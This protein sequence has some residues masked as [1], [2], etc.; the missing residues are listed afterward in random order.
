M[1]AMAALLLCAIPHANAAG[2]GT[3]I[4]TVT[5]E[6]T[7]PSGTVGSW[8]LLTPDQTSLKFST[9]THTI[10]VY[11]TGNY[12]LF[13]QSPAGMSA[14]VFLYKG[15]ALVTSV[16]RPQISFVIAEGDAPLRITLNYVL[17]RTGN[18]SVN[19]D[20][21][22]IP[23]E[24]KGPND[25]SIT[26]ITPY[27]IT[28]TPVG[29]YVIQYLPPGCVQPKP[30]SQLL[31]K[32][33]RLNFGIAISCAT[34]Q[35]DKEETVEENDDSVNMMVG[36][37][38]VNFSDVPQSSWFAPYVFAV[39]KTGVMSGYKDADG[40]PLGKFGP[41][42]AVTIGELAKLAHEIAGID[43]A[44]VDTPAENRGARGEWFEPYVA[45]AESL[46][47]LI[48]QDPKLDL[49]RPATRGEVI[50]TLLQALDVPLLW[51]KGKIFTDVFRRTPFAAA[52]ETAATKKIVSGE[53]TVEAPRGL[54]HP[55]DPINRAEIAKILSILIDQFKRAK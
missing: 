43:E 7:G 26:G 41:E 25:W 55:G 8:T 21:S 47:W 44:E 53:G 33:G 13:A 52:I 50:I 23:F 39:V 28:S 14:K 17:S 22:G 31:Q 42:N 30:Q 49:L 24:L 40:N 54:F 45:S 36:G 51:P 2:S 20:P 46:D 5:I 37:E 6:Q 34:L 15:G 3:I 38:N 11:K 27:A 18:V 16:D 12:T 19:S 1:F 29:Q 4:N 32:D 35:I 9:A 48:Y 10:S